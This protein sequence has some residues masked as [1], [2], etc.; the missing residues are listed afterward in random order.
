MSEKINWKSYFCDLCNQKLDNASE[1]GKA[2]V[3][4]CPTCSAKVTEI[5]F[6][7]NEALGKYL[8]K[9]ITEKEYHNILDRE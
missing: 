4:L 8:R 6:K 9:E 3:E 2:H 7:E 5:M 1:E